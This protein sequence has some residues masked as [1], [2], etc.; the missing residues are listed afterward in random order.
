MLARRTL[1][2][3]KTRQFMAAQRGAAL[4]NFPEAPS[5]SEKVII[6]APPLVGEARHVRL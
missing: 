1:Y 5:C 3:L 4:A 6:M 2:R